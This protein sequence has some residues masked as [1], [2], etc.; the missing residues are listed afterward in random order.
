MADTVPTCSVAIDHSFGPWAGNECR[1]GFDFTL[2]FEESIL[3]LPLQCLFLLALPF[4]VCQLANTETKV[5]PSIRRPLKIVRFILYTAL[6]PKKKKKKKK[7]P[8]NALSHELICHLGGCFLVPFGLEC[9]PTG[10]L[11]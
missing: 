10:P 1:G 5:V 7:N 11:V 4:R 8:I 3:T 2:L 9:R 6:L